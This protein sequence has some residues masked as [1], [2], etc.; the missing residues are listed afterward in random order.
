EGDAGNP[1][2]VSAQGGDRFPIPRIPDPHGPVHAC[3]SDARAVPA[4]G[5][6]VNPARVPAEGADRLLGEDVPDHDRV[7]SH[8]RRQAS[9]IRAERHASPS[10]HEDDVG[11]LLTESGDLLARLRVPD[12][13]RSRLAN[14]GDPAVVWAERHAVTRLTFPGDHSARG[15]VPDLD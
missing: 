4:V 11:R 2:S 7:I 8:G 3:R 1:A 14:R 9:A 13:Y 10:T 6:P 12:L 5:H 15:R